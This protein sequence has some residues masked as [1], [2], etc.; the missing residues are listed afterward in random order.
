[1][2]I[3]TKEIRKKSRE[4]VEM[5][6]WVESLTVKPDGVRSISGSHIARTN[7]RKPSFDLYKHNPV[8]TINKQKKK[9]ISG[10]GDDLGS[11]VLSVVS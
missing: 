5:A 2:I 3:Q 11:Q 4:P 1:M 10:G 9:R 8:H 7:S 6:Q